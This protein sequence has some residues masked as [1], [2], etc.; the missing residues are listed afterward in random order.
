MRKRQKAASSG[1]QQSKKPRQEFKY[2]WQP[3]V[4]DCLR[5]SPENLPSKINVA[6]RALSARLLDLNSPDRQELI[7]LREALR[8]LRAVLPEQRKPEQ[9][10]KSRFIRKLA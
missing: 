10:K 7:A 2:A 9:S 4:D 8:T 6:E 3:L 1:M 5:A